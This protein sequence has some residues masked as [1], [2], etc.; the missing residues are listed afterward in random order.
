MVFNKDILFIHIG[1][2]GGTSAAKYLC[3]VLAP[4]VYNVIPERAHKLGKVGNETLLVGQRHA[5]LEEAKVFLKKMDI[6]IN[7]FK[8]IIAVIRHPYNLEISLFN[9]YK[10]LLK[11][12]SNI[13]DN[14]PKRKEIVESGSFSDFV[15]GKFYH[16]H[17]INIRKYVT[18]N[19]KIHKKIQL[20]KYES[21]EEE[22]LEI[23]RIYGIKK[24]EF[25]HLNKTKK[26]ELEKYINLEIEHFIYRKYL[27]VFSVGD[28]QRLY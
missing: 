28:Y 18:I 25:P 26:I 6:N 7:S 11:N 15:K 21:L 13:L 17:K 14:A 10:R 1:K 8:K 3:N 2:T 20:I 22:F 16:R 9:Y 5:T 27:W 19:D 4:P 24:S 23:G 12:Q